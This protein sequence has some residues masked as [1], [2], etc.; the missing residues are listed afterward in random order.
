M[1]PTLPKLL[2]TALLAAQTL[3]AATPSDVTVWNDKTMGQV[4]YT[5]GDYSID[6]RLR[7]NLLL[8]TTLRWTDKEIMAT[9]DQ[10]IDIVWSTSDGEPSETPLSLTG[11]GKVTAENA[12]LY[13]V[14]GITN[15]PNDLYLSLPYAP[16]TIG[17]GIT[18]EN[19]HIVTSHKGATIN[20]TLNNCSIEPD[21][22]ATVDLTRATLSG[23]R[24]Y[25]YSDSSTVIAPELKLDGTTAIEVE[26][27]GNT[28][29]G[30]VTMNTGTYATGEAYLKYDYSRSVQ[31]NLT[32]NG[33]S[34]EQVRTATQYTFAGGIVFTPTRKVTM[35]ILNMKTGNLS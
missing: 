33:V 13:Q 22:E 16:T 10:Y 21:F 12:E 11:S 23:S 30:N 3:T 32:A 29:Q 8:N 26:G 7:G 28:I 6:E 34:A 19:I 5:D 27:D 2:L 1:K 15:L 25:F 14:L 17:E 18:L 4:H 20:G 24:I 31:Q 35:S 9:D